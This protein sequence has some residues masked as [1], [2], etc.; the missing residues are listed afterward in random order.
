MVSPT[1]GLWTNF[2]ASEWLVIHFGFIFL[3]VLVCSI[4]GF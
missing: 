2:G 1:F 3:Q 4:F